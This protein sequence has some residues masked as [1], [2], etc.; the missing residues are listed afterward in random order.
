MIG[1]LSVAAATAVGAGY[2]ISG[3]IATDVGLHAA[4]LFGAL[5]SV[6]AFAAAAWKIPS[7][8]AS[9][10]RRLDVRGAV[11]GTVGL[12]ALLL[13]IG[14]GQVWG[15]D[16]PS[17]VGLFIVAA[18]ILTAWTRLQLGHS[19][20]LVDLRQLRHRS[21][22]TADLAAIVLGIAMYMFLTV[23]T[24]FVQEPRASGYG[25]SATVLVAGLCL[26]PFSATSLLASRFTPAIARALTTTG[27]LVG[28]SFVIAAAGAFFAIA[29][30]AC[31]R[32]WWRWACSGSA[33]A[34]RSRRC[35]AWSP[36]R[37]RDRRPAARWG[38]IR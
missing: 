7:S 36:G 12:A 10:P 31:G 32:R 9:G 8:R 26:V 6:L 37:P 19:A 5:I 25:L 16:S 1:L 27:V 20:P 38:C 4:F 2:P 15:W 34:A 28:G 21:V 29:H 22:L 35:R 3:L 17:I 24:E 13:A 23:I 30:G 33:L 18:V 11:V 14:Q